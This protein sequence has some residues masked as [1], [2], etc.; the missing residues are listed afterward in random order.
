[1]G[2]PAEQW[3]PPYKELERLPENL[4]G[5]IINGR[6]ITHPRPAGPHGQAS[7]ALG[8]GILPPYQFGRGGPGGWWIIDEPE[9][10]FRRDWEVLVPDLAGWRRERMPRPPQDHRYEVTPD[11]VCEILSPGT[12]KRDRTEKMPL[13]ARYGV[14]WLWLLDPLLKTL[15]AYELQGG[16]WLNIG[17]HKDDDRIRLAPFAEVEIGLSDLWLPD[18]N[19]PNP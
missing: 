2:Q 14:A 17:T 11:W 5:E 15:E 8:A 3:I 13:Y 10:H 4:V 19:Q 9:L 6:L 12:A 18:E 16:R 1:M 7:S